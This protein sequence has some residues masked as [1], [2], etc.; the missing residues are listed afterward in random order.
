MRV[1][2]RAH[3]GPLSARGERARVARRVP[4]LLRVRAAT[5]AAAVVLYPGPPGLLQAGLR[6]VS[7]RSARLVACKSHG[8]GSDRIVI[9]IVIISSESCTDFIRFVC[10]YITMP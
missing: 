10:W 1:V 4:A 6:Q 8:I 3:R 7:I 5:G 2:R 9:Q